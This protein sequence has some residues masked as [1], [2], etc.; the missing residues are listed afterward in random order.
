MARWYTTEDCYLKTDPVSEWEQ[1]ETDALTGRQLR[2]V[3]EVP[4][5]IP[6]DSTVSNGSGA[7]R[8]DIIFVGPPTP[9]MQPL[10]D[11]A[12][13]ITNKERHKW[14][15][16]I[17][18]LRATGQDRPYDYVVVPADVPPPTA[19]PRVKSGRRV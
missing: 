4:T 17:E 1:K 14:V 5:Q 18:S 11:E 8:G 7:Q 10:D 2:K 9:A 12:E 3:F 16:P 13:A 15:H 19:V 6:K